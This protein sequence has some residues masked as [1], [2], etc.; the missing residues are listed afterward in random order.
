MMS[1][2]LPDDLLRRSFWAATDALPHDS[3]R[4]SGVLRKA[5]GRRQAR[6]R[7][8]SVGAAALAVVPLTIAG[9]QRS[10]RPPVRVVRSGTPAIL[11]RPAVTCGPHG[12]QAHERTIEADREGAHV[13]FRNDRDDA[14]EWSTPSSVGTVPGGG[15]AYLTLLDG[16]GSVRLSCGLASGGDEASVQLRITDPD[17]LYVSEA[18]SCRQPPPPR[19]TEPA[20][21]AAAAPAVPFRGEAEQGV[22]TALT[23]ARVADLRTRADV[24]EPAGY[25]D[26]GVRVFRVRRHE[27]VWA[28]FRWAPAAGQRADGDDSP[29]APNGGWVLQS[30]ATCVPL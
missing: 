22:P 3:A 9:I 17:R 2:P 20:P 26:A 29:A 28:V 23:L 11:A 14:V 10:V 18:L 8:V 27:Q 24:V 5:A 6:R 21:V 19:G 25:P 30:S 1:N 13:W 12:M 4:W 15:S 16:P 7:T